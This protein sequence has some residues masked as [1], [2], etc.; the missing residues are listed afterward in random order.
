MRGFVWSI[1]RM[2]SCAYVYEDGECF[3]GCQPTCLDDRPTCLTHAW[4]SNDLS[5]A[6]LLQRQIKSV[7]LSVF[8]KANRLIE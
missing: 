4:P 2:T 6:F 5:V 3:D 8:D 1:V 7:L